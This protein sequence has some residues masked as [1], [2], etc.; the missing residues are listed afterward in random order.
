MNNTESKEKKVVM[1]GNIHA[2]MY[3]LDCFMVDVPNL[4]INFTVDS[5]ESQAEELLVES[6]MKYIAQAK[7]ELTDWVER[8]IVPVNNWIPIE[9]KTEFENGKRYFI[10]N[11]TKKME[12]SFY[13][14]C[15]YWSIS[16]DPKTTEPTLNYKI[17]KTD[18]KYY[19]PLPEAKQ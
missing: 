15:W 6:V 4:C 11:E 12:A 8:K 18:A 1:D 2:A 5:I 13:D 3:L 7:Q 16:T 14:N 19:Q 9:D 17:G 10:C